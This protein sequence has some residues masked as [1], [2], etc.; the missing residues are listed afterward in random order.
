M[1]LTSSAIAVLHEFYS[2]SDKSCIKM[3][4]EHGGSK[5]CVT[6]ECHNNQKRLYD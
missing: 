4:Y 6:V 2:I 3:P 5:M 1:A